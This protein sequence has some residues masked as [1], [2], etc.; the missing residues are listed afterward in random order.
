MIRFGA[1]LPPPQS[2]EAWVKTVREMGYNAAYVPLTEKASQ[3]ERQEYRQAAQEADI[4]LAEVGAWSNLVSPDREIRE[5][6]FRLNV[7]RLRLAEDMGA[8]CCV[9]VTGSKGTYWCGED[10]GN[11]APETYDEIVDV[12]RRIVDEADPRNTYYTVEFMQWAVPDS[13][14][15]YLSLIRD[16]DRERFAVHLDPVNI[17]NSPDKYYASGAIIRDAF[18]RL[19]PYLRSCH[20]KD[21]IMTSE[22][23]VHISETPIGTGILDYH[24]YLEEMTAYP[25]VP[26]MLEHLPDQAAYV[27]AAGVLRKRAR[28]W[29]F[30]LPGMDLKE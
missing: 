14:D 7:D 27:K 29:G 3:T 1:P 16:V 5:N 2:P 28:E 12:V 15:S 17:L 8:R 30:E 24:T 18:R 21:I 20:A 19:G 10:P 25:D 9:N 26:L 4:V 13:V 22:F 23:L 6:A 11:Y